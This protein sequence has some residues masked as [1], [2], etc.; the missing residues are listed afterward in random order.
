MP[1]AKRGTVTA[2]IGKAIKDARGGLDWLGV[3][4]GSPQKA[5]K[6]APD[7]AMVSVPI[8]SISFDEAK[9]QENVRQFGR[10]LLDVCNGVGT[11]AEVAG[12][13][14]QKKKKAAIEKMFLKTTMSMSIEVTDAEA[15]IGAA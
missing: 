13:A 7:R 14:V 8:A 12:D 15:L 2:E 4:I 6:N 11:Q 5:D 9:I 10:E 1:S 3:S